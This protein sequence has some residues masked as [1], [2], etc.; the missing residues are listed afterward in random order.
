[1]DQCAKVLRAIAQVPIFVACIALFFLMMMTFADV[2]LRSTINAP[3][4]AATE[5]TRMSI[6]VVVFAS[7][8]VLSMNGGHISVDLIDPLFSKMGLLRIRDSAMAIVC[9]VLLWWPA[10]RVVDLAERSRSYGDT[11][12]YLNWPVFYIGYFIAIMTFASMVALILRGVVLLI[13]PQ[14]L[15][16]QV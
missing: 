6:A 14:Y 1:M 11:T 2:I 5:L 15:K 12:E 4:E 3:I 16:A 10:N 9:G 7:M 8:P 13:A